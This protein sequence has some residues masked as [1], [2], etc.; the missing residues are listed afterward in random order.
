MKQLGIGDDVLMYQGVILGG[1]TLEKKKCH[2][3][4][5]NN[6]VVG[7]PGKISMGSSARNFQDLEHGKIP[8]PI[9]DDIIT[10]LRGQEKLRQRIERLEL[11]QGKSQRR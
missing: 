6:V 2:P 7:V 3:I 5:R 1:T 9:A 10:L 11:R 4:L 8:D